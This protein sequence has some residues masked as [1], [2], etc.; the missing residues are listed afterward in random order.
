MIPCY[1]L[2]LRLLQPHLTAIASFKLLSLRMDIWSSTHERDTTESKHQA[3]LPNCLVNLIKKPSVLFRVL[4]SN[5]TI[6]MQNG[7]PAFLSLPLPSQLY[8]SIRISSHMID[9][10]H[11]RK[12]IAFL[13]PERSFSTYSIF[14]I[15]WDIWY[16]TDRGT[17]YQLKE[18]AHSY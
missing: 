18:C 4:N 3:K 16:G 8:A 17:L 15:H 9:T 14:T 6:C 11:S 5:D 1:G 12:H 7:A 13:I 2:G 10:D